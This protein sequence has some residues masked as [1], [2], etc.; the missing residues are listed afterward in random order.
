MILLSWV[1][2]IHW[3]DIGDI[4][5]GAACEAGNAYT[6]GAP[7]FTSGFD[8]GSCCPVLLLHVIVSSFVFWVL[9]V[10]FVWLLGIYIFYFMCLC[11]YVTST[12]C[13]QS[14]CVIIQLTC[15]VTLDCIAIFDANIRYLAT[16]SLHMDKLLECLMNY[17]L[18]GGICRL[19]GI[20]FYITL[21]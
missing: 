13:E 10:P 18:G 6:S 12:D 14:H 21:K 20:Y 3:Y 9:I 7:D 4:M 2:F 5:T 15:P 19:Y 8:R 1:R 11:M 17:L 16:R